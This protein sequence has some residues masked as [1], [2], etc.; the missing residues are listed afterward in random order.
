MSRARTFASWLSSLSDK[1]AGIRVELGTKSQAGSTLGILAVAGRNLQLS[2]SAY[3]PEEVELAELATYIEEL[4]RGAGWPEEIPKMRL[5]ALD[6]KGRNITSWQKTTKTS[7][8]TTSKTDTVI[9][10]EQMA[11]IL[12]RQLST[13]EKLVATQ[14]ASIDSLSDANSHAMNTT[15]HMIDGMIESREYAADTAAANAYLETV[16]TEQGEAEESPF[17]GLA[18]DA[19]ASI[20]MTNG[21]PAGE[22]LDIEAIRKRAAE[23]HFFRMDLEELLKPSDDQPEEKT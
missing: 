1:V 6:A 17:V 20:G 14:S 5:Y 13:I 23:D 18:R 9:M 7:K 10:F 8:E 11:D 3:V 15:I 19:L 22:E 12:S 2:D 21:E 16:M 4:A